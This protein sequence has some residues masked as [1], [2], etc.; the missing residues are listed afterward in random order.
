MSFSRWLGLAGC[1]TLAMFFAAGA[2]WCF[3]GN[4]VMVGALVGLP[5]TIIFGLMALVVVGCAVA[6]LPYRGALQRA[7]FFILLALALAFL[8]LGYAQLQMQDWAWFLT[9]G[10]SAF[11]LFLLILAIDTEFPTGVGA[12]T[13][14]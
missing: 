13:S 2:V 5:F 7:P 4:R 9:S 1:Y 8:T 10:G 12:S 6:F 14:R 11:F 3:V